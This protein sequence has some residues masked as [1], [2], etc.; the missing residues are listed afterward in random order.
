MLAEYGIHVRILEHSLLDHR[1]RATSALLFTWL[2]QQLHG[3]AEFVAII[4]Q[5]TTDTQQHGG[6]GIMTAGVHDALVLAD[7]FDIVLFNYRKSIHIST[8]ED[9]LF[10][11]FFGAL[12]Q[13]S[14]SSNGD[15]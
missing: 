15:T 5:N 3:S 14:N 4:H 11:P 8:E 6:M 1:E 9:N 13:G 2:E 10:R 7:I 12:H